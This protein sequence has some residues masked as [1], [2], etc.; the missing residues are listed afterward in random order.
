MFKRSSL[1]IPNPESNSVIISETVVVVETFVD[2]GDVFV[3]P[4]ITI[5]E[6]ATKHPDSKPF[7]FKINDVNQQITNGDIEVGSIELETFRNIP[8]EELFD[9]DG[10]P[11]PSTAERDRRYAIVLDLLALEDELFYPTHGM[12]LIAKVVKQHCTTQTNAQRYLNEYFRGGRNKNALIS[13]RGRHSSASKNGGRKVGRKR[14][15]AEEYGINGKSIDEQDKAYIKRIA[16]KYYLT[17]K[18]ISLEKCYQHLLEEFYY[19]ERFLLPNGTYKYEFKHPNEIISKWQFRDWMPLV[20]GLTRNQIQAIRR[21]HS[22]HKSNFA[23]RKGDSAPHA[24]GPNHVWQL[25]STP[26]DVELVAPYDRRVLIKVVTLY[27][28]RDVYTRSICGIHIGI[29]PASWAEARLALF[30]AIRNKVDYARECGL[31]I[32]E[33]DW[34]ESGSP[35]FLLVDNEELQN[36]LSESVTAHMQINVLFARAYEGDDK[37]LVESSFHMIHAMAR[38]E[39]IP[40]FKYKNLKGRNR[41]IPQKTASLTPYDLK[42]ILILFAIKHNNTTWKQDYPIEQQALFEGVKPVCRDYWLWGEDNR[43]YFMRD[44]SEREI[45]LNL[46]EVGVLTVHKTHLHLQDKGINYCCEMISES[47]FQDKPT[48]KGKI[49]KTLKCRYFRGNMSRILI[50]FEGKLRVGVL[51]SNHR[52]FQNMSLDEIKDAKKH[53]LALEQLH[54]LESSVEVS[55][56]TQAIQGVVNSSKLAKAEDANDSNLPFELD[57]RAEASEVLA[58]QADVVE[59]DRLNSAIDQQGVNHSEIGPDDETIVEAEFDNEEESEFNI[60]LEEMLND[61]D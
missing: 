29:G 58:L 40:G 23:G 12:G 3:L 32:D 2:R 39:Q 45:Y 13:R 4:Y 8:E 51:H 61:E 31:E 33:S 55:N 27:V 37:G 53:W 10:K 44:H 54:N 52:S 30:H 24:L 7:K 18:R 38:N 46:L 50:E 42:K 43:G 21:G 34:V 28:I 22:E 41:N 11:Y 57:N 9:K 17:K 16:K 15:T 56:S 47:G 59:T 19:K 25:D 35:L 60:L 48:L 1:F 20:L 6:N 14:A 49:H 26:I 5:G 36:K